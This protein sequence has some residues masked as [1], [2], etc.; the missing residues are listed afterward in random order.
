MTHL[1]ALALLAC[2]VAALA[3]AGWL[4]KSEMDALDEN[5]DPIEQDEQP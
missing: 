4:A 2:G 5:G 3:A 1:F